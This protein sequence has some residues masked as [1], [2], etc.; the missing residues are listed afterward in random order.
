[1]HPIDCGGKKGVLGV[2]RLCL[3]TKTV[4]DR[5]AFFCDRDLDGI[6]DAS[7]AGCDRLYVTR[8]YS[9]ESYMADV[10]TLSVV[11]TEIFSLELL[12][13]RLQNCLQCFSGAYDRFR[14]RLTIVMA[15]VLWCRRSG[16]NPNLANVSMD[17]LFAVDVL[18]GSIA[19]AKKRGGL[20]HLEKACQVAASRC[21]PAV[22]S[23]VG[24]LRATAFKSYARGKWDL[25]FFVAVALSL[26]DLR[27]DHSRGLDAPRR[28]VQMTHANAVD[29]LAPRLSEPQ[30]LAAFLDR[31]C[32]PIIVRAPTG[33]AGISTIASTGTT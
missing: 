6:P 15:W 12:D 24:E 19:V 13:E 17:A 18:P 26:A 30:D 14:R 31:V 2:L 21:F 8:H 11:W 27:A 33:A 29:L 3:N 22:R 9:I 23:I 7:L 28:Q 32:A 5:A 1:M 25:W 4:L 10:S 20:G 16:G